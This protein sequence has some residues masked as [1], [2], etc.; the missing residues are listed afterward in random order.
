[1][2]DTRWTV[3][4]QSPLQIMQRSALEPLSLWVVNMW[5]VVVNITENNTEFTRGSRHGREP[6]AASA[7]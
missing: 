1:M 3:A 2:A 4:E 7:G 6:C 5:V